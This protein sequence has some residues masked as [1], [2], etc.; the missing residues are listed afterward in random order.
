MDYDAPVA[1]D[2]HGY[3]YEIAVLAIDPRF[4]Q[5]D[6][7]ARAFTHKERAAAPVDWGTRNFAAG[8]R[9]R[10]FEVSE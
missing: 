5:V 7:P 9:K 3:R 4:A 6:G 8:R 10:T 2:A 1:Y